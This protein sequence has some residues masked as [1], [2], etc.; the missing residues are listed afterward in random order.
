MGIS[1]A[2]RVL[3]NCS[4]IPESIVELSPQE[5]PEPLNR[6]RVLGEEKVSSFKEVQPRTGNLFPQR[7]QAGGVAIPSYR[8]PQIYTGICNK[9]S[10]S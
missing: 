2:H 3:G 4:H 1:S 8:P 9:G 6:P 7:F 10:R 5:R